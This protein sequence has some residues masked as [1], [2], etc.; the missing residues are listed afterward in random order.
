[1]IEIFLLK[2][3][4]RYMSETRAHVGWTDGIVRSGVGQIHGFSNFIISRSMWLEAPTYR[5]T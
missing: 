3:K 4:G 1:M 5:K 2:Y